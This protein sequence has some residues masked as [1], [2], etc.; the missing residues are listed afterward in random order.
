M[1]ERHR[2]E[3]AQA[4]M[5]LGRPS[6]SSVRTAIG[7]RARR[8][9]IPARPRRRESQRRLRARREALNETTWHL[10]LEASAMFV[11]HAVRLIQANRRWMVTRRREPDGGFISVL[12]PEAS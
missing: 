12:P 4:R 7:I 9:R 3:A 10:P 11:A 1:P 8:N 6:H 5:H 2:D